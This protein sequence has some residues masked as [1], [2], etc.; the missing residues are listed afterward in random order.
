M[1]EKWMACA[2]FV[3][4]FC[5]VCASQSMFSLVFPKSGGQVAGLKTLCPSNS[6]TQNQHKQQT[7][8][9]PTNKL[10]YSWR[11]WLKKTNKLPNRLS[12]KGA[13]STKTRQV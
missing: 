6:D 9:N 8:N 3:R 11:H 10:Q 7:T 4:V 12:P 1:G 13:S 2:L 5:V